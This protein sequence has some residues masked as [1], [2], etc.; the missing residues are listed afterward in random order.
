MVGRERQLSITPAA[1]ARRVVI[2]GGG[3]AGMEAARIAALRGHDVVLLE[4]GVTLGGR[5]ELAAR[6]YAPN[7]ELLRWLI[8]QVEQFDIDV[9]LGTTADGATIEAL[10][11]DVVVDATGGRWTKP[12]IDGVNGAHVRDLEACT[13]WVLHDEPLADGPVVVIGGGRAGCGLADLAH[14]H[15]HPTTVLESS[16]V[17]AVQFG[18]PGRWRYVHDLREQGLELVGDAT[19]THIV[20]E[21]VHYTVAGAEHTVAATTVITVNQVEANEPLALAGFGGVETYRVGD[22]TGPRWLEGS[23]YDATKAAV[24]I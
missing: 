1:H 22:C 13:P 4:R 17:F 23:F 16:N 12:A 7:A 14:R 21:A 24:A 5:F 19:V 6:T 18:L 11:P 10:A 15:G 8:R 9:R 20:D 2:A 3:P